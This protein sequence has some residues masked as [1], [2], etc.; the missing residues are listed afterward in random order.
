MANEPLKKGDRV[1]LLSM[2]N[3]PHPVP[4]GTEGECIAES[5][6]PWE[7]TYEINWDNGSSLSL[8][9]GTDSWEKINL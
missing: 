9:V 4:N 1:K 5:K 3:D 6:T 7:K 2:S 8:L